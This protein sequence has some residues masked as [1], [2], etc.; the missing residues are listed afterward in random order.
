M[1]RISTVYS[2]TTCPTDATKTPESKTHNACAFGRR[3]ISAILVVVPHMVM[4]TA[5]S[6]A[7]GFAIATSTP[8][9]RFGQLGADLGG[10]NRIASTIC[11]G[12][13]CFAGFFVSVVAALPGLLIGTVAGIG[14]GIYQLPAAL[15]KS[16]DAGVLPVLKEGYELYDIGKRKKAIATG[17]AVATLLAA[18]SFILLAGMVGGPPLAGL[19]AIFEIPAYLASLTTLTYVFT[20]TDQYQHPKPEQLPGNQVH[21]STASLVESRNGLTCY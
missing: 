9:T 13:G 1:E 6:A 10:D 12:I 8:I 15:S 18:S 5:L 21:A 14:A 11:H 2:P 19:V 17:I 16:Y 20:H 4:H 7:S 3:V